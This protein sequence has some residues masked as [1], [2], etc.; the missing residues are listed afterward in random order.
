MHKPY[1]LLYI[2][3]I[4]WLQN[5]ALFDCQKQAISQRPK[6]VRSR[7]TFGHWELDTVVS[8]RGK[9]KGCVATFV[10]RK[11][12]LYTAILMPDRTALSME[13]AFGVAAAQ[14]P[15][16]AFQTATADRGKEFACYAS[17]EATHGVQVYFADPTRFQ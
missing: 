1:L 13:I 8:G 9:S 2:D 12:R 16:G 14:Y 4:A 15:T 11:T 10:E 3:K 6:E 17:L 7:E 5:S